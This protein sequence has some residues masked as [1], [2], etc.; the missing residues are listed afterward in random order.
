MGKLPFDLEIS[1]ISALADVMND[2]HL[3]EICLESKEAG[4]KLTLKAAR[5]EPPQGMPM[6]M[7]PPMQLAGAAAP[8]QTAASDSPCALDVPKGN[9][10]KSPIVGT[11]YSSPAPGKP[12]FVTVGSKVCKGD[13]VMIIES[14]K[15]MNEVRSDFDGVVKEILVKNGDAVEYDQPIMIL[16]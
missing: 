8:A 14:M 11:Y 13:V 9:A 12:P 7:M 4:C 5:P 16:E 6:P 3:G 2:K 15:L 10:V 1:D